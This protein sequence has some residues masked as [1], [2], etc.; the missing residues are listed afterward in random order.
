MPE[1]IL[2]VEDELALR[3]TLTYNLQK[4]GYAVEA[5]SD[6]RTALEAARVSDHTAMMM[7]TEDRRSGTV[8]EYNDTNVIF[9]RPRDK[10]TE[11]YVAGRFG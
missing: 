10:R 6:G 1:T 4:E 2:V 9:T 3:D 11:D 5:V 7:L 8:I